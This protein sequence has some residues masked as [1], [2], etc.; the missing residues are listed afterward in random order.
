MRCAGLSGLEWDVTADLALH[1]VAEALGENYT[2]RD[3]SSAGTTSV[4]PFR[5]T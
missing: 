3:T 2:V 4:G 5:S 1:N